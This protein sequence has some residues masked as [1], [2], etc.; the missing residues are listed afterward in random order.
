MVQLNA[1]H[2]LAM[3]IGYQIAEYT[4]LNYHTLELELKTNVAYTNLSLAWTKVKIEA[5][6]KQFV[7]IT[8]IRRHQSKAGVALWNKINSSFLRFFLSPSF[9][10]QI[11]Q[12]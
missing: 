3:G 9:L 7:N 11:P 2:L 4:I 8:W 10:L 5:A 1:N 6:F 12:L